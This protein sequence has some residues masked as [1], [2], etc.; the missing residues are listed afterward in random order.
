[1][2]TSSVSGSA[3]HYLATI[4][5]SDQNINL[6]A[7]RARDYVLFLMVAMEAEAHT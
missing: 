4:V 5:D 6:K 3:G 1:M 2:L 7:G